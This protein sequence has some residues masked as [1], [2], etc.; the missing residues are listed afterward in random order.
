M[1]TT[2]EEIVAKIYKNLRNHY[3]LQ[4][5]KALADFLN[6]DYRTLSAWKTRGNIA[7]IDAFV[8]KC[9]G[10]NIDWLRTGQGEMFINSGSHQTEADNTPRLDDFNY[11]PLYN[12]EL[13]AG[14]GALVESEEITARYAFRKEW[15]RRITN[16]PTTL[17]L[18]LVKGDS[19]Y[20]TLS[21]GDIVMIDTAKKHLQ[22][23]GIYCINIGGYAAV[24]RIELGVTGKARIISDNTAEYPL[25]EADLS[26]LRIIGQVIWYA[27]E[28]IRPGDSGI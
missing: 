25:Y 14:H 27:R 13:S 8:D 9:R 6:I 5:D 12:V 16:S 18:C 17:A 26:D 10:I 24:K 15:V 19:M 3:N 11:I 28:L 2:N 7:K 1:S 23:N 4:T 22:P 20:P 21:E